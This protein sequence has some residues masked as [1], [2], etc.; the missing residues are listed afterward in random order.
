MS[1]KEQE[2]RQ[3]WKQ[4]QKEYP[5]V[6]K[7]IKVADDW[8]PNYPDGT[9]KG[10]VS[11]LLNPEYAMENLEPIRGKYVIHISFWGYDDT[12]FE[13][14]HYAKRIKEAVT[15]YQEYIDYM[16]KIPENINL[17]EYLIK[18]DFRRA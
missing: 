12:G 13:K 4:L 6:E 5:E 1:T 18:D 2:F 15:I 14:W 8:S 9:V 10:R 11:I 16:N 7:R 17:K 3:E